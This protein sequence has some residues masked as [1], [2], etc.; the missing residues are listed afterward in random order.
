MEKLNSV[1]ITFGDGDL[2]YKRAAKRLAHEAGSTG[3]YKEIFNFDL[4]WL[5]R[6]DTELFHFA[7]RCLRQGDLIGMGYWVWKSAAINWAARNFPNHLI[8]YLDA[9]HVILPGKT[10]IDILRQ[11]LEEAQEME[12]LAWNLPGYPEI[13]WT[14]RELVELLDPNHLHVKTPQVEAGFLIMKSE[15]AIH[16]SNQLRSTF[17]LDDGKYLKGDIWLHQEP[18]FVSHRYDQSVHSLLWKINGYNSRASETFPPRNCNSVI[19]A[20]HAS[21]FPWSSE[22]SSIFQQIEFF[23]GKIQKASLIYINPFLRRI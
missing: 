7:E 9:G 15:A 2:R 4:K 10:S 21:G 23:V 1:L 13:S 19:A 6:N 16:F 22:G 14:K 5:S 20:R 8:H 18:E 11:W 3:L 17:L 12:T